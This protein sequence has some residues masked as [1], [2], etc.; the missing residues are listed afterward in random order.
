[1]TPIIITC[2][3]TSAVWLYVFRNAVKTAV[4]QTENRLEGKI[5]QLESEAKASA[6]VKTAETDIHD[7]AKKL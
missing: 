5:A 3:I 6:M 4:S 2:L 7:I 1:M